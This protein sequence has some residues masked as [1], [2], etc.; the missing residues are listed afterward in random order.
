[1]ATLDTIL[2]I[3]TY[4]L[5]LLLSWAVPWSVV[6]DDCLPGGN[7]FGIILVVDLSFIC[8]FAVSKIQLPTLPPL[9]SLL[10]MLFA[11]FLLANIPNL[12]ITSNILPVWS[13]SLRSVALSIILVKAGLD[14]DPSVLNKMKSV[15]T[16]LTIVPCLVETASCAVAA[17]FL[18]DF[19]W[20]W[21]FL[22][23]FVL[24][25]VTPAVIVPSLLKLQSDG[26]GVNEGIPSLVIAASS[27]D[28]VVAISGFSVVFSIIFSNVET[29]N[30]STN[31]SFN[32]TSLN[33][34]VQIQAENQETSL[35]MLILRGPLE[36]IG[37]VLFSLLIG[38]TLWKIPLSGNKDSLLRMRSLLVVCI[39]IFSIF[40]T[41]RLNV[42]GC[43][44]IMAITIPFVASKKWKDDKEEI[45]ENVG[46][47]WKVFEPVM[48]GLIGAEVLIDKMDSGIIGLG[49]A[50]LL[51]CL[52]FRIL[53]TFAAVSFAGFCFKEKMFLCLSWLPKAT[54]QAAIGGVALDRA[55]QVSADD[56]V[57]KLANQVLAISV[58]SIMITAPLGALF[59]GITGPKLLRR[60]NDNKG[61]LNAELEV[62]T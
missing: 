18:L 25:A 54:V 16:R 50:T 44:A 7:L 59:I 36:M 19:P 49:I 43:G 26:Y 23:G 47:C 29:S 28:D 53:A 5:F 60:N 41:N 52:F 34:T 13:S 10:G 14:L 33:S 51:I 31:V 42:P 21:G 6:G 30:Q 17:H 38:A 61:G 24:G 46:K 56:H 22:L 48:F 15:C 3:I 39:G 45:S 57:M 8:G 32:S 20:L 11:G 35:A 27:F 9:P 37:G 62:L 4:G 1:M 58:L 40:A 2:S 55:R 12:A